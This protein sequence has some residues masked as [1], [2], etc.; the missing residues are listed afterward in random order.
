MVGINRRGLRRASSSQGRLKFPRRSRGRRG[1]ACPSREPARV[2]ASGFAKGE[3]GPA[4]GTPRVLPRGLYKQRCRHKMR[5]WRRRCIWTLTGLG[6]AAAIDMPTRDLRGWG[7]RLRYCARRRRSRRS[8]GSWATTCRRS[9]CTV[10]A[11][12]TTSPPSGSAGRGGGSSGTA[13]GQLTLV[14]FD[15]HP[16]WDVRPPRWACGG[17]VCR[18]L[19]M[20]HVRG[21][22]VWGCG[23]FELALPV[24]A[25]RQPLGPARRPAQVHAWAE[26]QKPAVCRRFDCMGRENWRER[27]ER[28]A[29]EL[30]GRE[31]YVTVDLDCLRAE[32]AATNWENGLFT[33]DDVAWAIGQLRG[34]GAARRRRPVRG[35]LA[36][37][38]RPAAAALRRQLGPPENA[39]APAGRGPP[40]QSGG[41]G[42]DL[43]G[44]DW[45]VSGLGSDNPEG[46]RQTGG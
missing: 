29:D 11:I 19:E 36:A 24:A 6:T 42:E 22:S 40:D 8:T 15:N 13:A 7:P 32:E 38:L 12:S 18:A 21:A 30:A 1:T 28:F 27:F 16:D 35:I 43:A 33:A 25:V 39:G 5:P 45:T 10:R 4:V 17:W 20:P 9:C 26:R 44:L 31:V 3:P 14:S 37:G 23:N 41:T 34:R 46:L 2:A